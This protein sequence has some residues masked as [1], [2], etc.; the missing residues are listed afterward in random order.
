VWR[1]LVAGNLKKRIERELRCLP[2]PHVSIPQESQKENW[3]TTSRLPQN[4]IRNFS[5]WISKRELK[6]VKARVKARAASS[7]TES[8][9]ENWKSK[10]TG[11]IKVFNIYRISKRE[12][13]VFI[14][15]RS[16][17]GG[18]SAPESQKENWKRIRWLLW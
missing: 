16:R 2:A 8:Q 15:F 7:S 17:G 3:K 5:Q 9:K 18:S 11:V 13:K 12:L 1:A 10:S 4:S 14:V 6:A